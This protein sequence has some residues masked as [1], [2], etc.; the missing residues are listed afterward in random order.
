[1]RAEQEQGS[2]TRVKLWQR[3]GQE[4][5][6]SLNVMSRTIL[7][8]EKGAIIELLLCARQ[9]PKDIST[10]GASLSLHNNLE[11]RYPHSADKEINVQGSRQLF[12]SPPNEGV[13]PGH[14][15]KSPPI[16]QRAFH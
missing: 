15:H 12:Q 16:S 1:M 4:G 5:T 3:A 14:A 8:C 11:M 13:E 9:T 10:H 2:G 7:W 6:E